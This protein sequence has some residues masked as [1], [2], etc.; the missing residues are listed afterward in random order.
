MSG[1]PHVHQVNLQQGFGGGEVFTRSFTRALLEAGC[2]VTLYVHAGSSA[3]RG[4]EHPELSLA[5]L[6]NES[7]LALRLPPERALVLTQ[8]PLADGI[9]QALA[10]RHFVAGFAHMP[11]AAGRD[12]AGFAH[13]ALVI[14][15]S[16]YV[17]GTLRAAG[18]AAVYAEPLYG[19]AD[20]ERTAGPRASGPILAASPYAWDRRKLR[21]RVLS[22]LHPALRAVQSRAAF[23]RRPGLALG[24]VS[25]LAPIKQLPLL[26]AHLSPVIA[27]FGDV[28]LEIFGHGGYAYVTDLRRALA[29]LGE[30]ARLWG[31]QQRVEAIY[32]RLDYVM[33]GLPEKEALGLNLIEA[34]ACG[35]PVLAVNAPPFIETVLEGRSGFLYRDPRQDGGADFR[36]VLEHVRGL[37]RRP[38]P[39]A[40]SAHL[41]RFAFPALLERTR[42]L[43]D[44]LAPRIGGTPP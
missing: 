8:A 33:S 32:P 14:P 4:L 5:A 40:A 22:W 9:L 42:A 13:H 34:Q 23:T 16:A 18:I 11:L 36:R 37:E 19:I 44:F 25:L 21:D 24:I 3:W 26:F 12:A 6:H 29:P 41:R 1:R 10:R 15:V 17:R 30:R 31:F 2:R 35:T 7:E 27:G 39:R 28:N 43:L 20:F 38:D